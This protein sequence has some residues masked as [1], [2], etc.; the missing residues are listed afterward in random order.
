MGNE[1]TTTKSHLDYLEYI[2]SI[3]I[4]GGNNE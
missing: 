1:I 4:Q 3:T 2:K